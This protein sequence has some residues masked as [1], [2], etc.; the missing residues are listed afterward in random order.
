MWKLGPELRE[1]CPEEF[2]ERITEA[3]GFN[4]YDEPNFRLVW[5]QTA[6][7]RAGGSWEVAGAPH[8]TGYRDLLSGSGEA[9]WLLQQ[10]HAPEEYGTPESYYVQNHDEASGLQ[11]LGEYPYSGRYETVQPLVYRHVVGRELV[12]EAMPL[13]SFLIDVV[14][15][16][17]VMCKD[18]SIH[19]KRAVMEERRERERR[20]EENQI[21]ASLRNAHPEFGEVRSAAALGCMSVV[22]KR[23]EQIEQHWK[24]AAS[25]IRRQGKGL[26]VLN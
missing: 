25:L 14:V 18:A 20:A 26:S 9:C 22:Q 24:S 17:I 21:E 13:S 19:A 12:S 2:Q 16:I 15:P 8:F 4:R 5:G 10:W 1:T 6:T 11:T 3:G 23:V 7:F